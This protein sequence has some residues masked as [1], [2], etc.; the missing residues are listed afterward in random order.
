MKKIVSLLLAISVCLSILPVTSVAVKAADYELSN[1]RTAAITGTDNMGN[2]CAD[3][4]TTWDCIWFG[5]YPQSDSTGAK[6]EPIKWRVLSCSGND[7]FILAD[8]SLDC[9]PYNKQF[10]ETSWETCTLR[11]WLNGTFFKKAFKTGEQS[12]VRTTTVVND[13]NSY[14]GVDG[15]NDTSDKVYVLSFGELTNPSYGFPDTYSVCSKTRAA[16][17][18]EYAINNGAYIVSSAPYSG[19][20]YWWTRSFGCDDRN[21]VNSGF[22]GY[23]NKDGNG[24][25]CADHAV[26]PALHINLASSSWSYAGTVCSDGTVVEPKNSDQAGTGSSG[27]T[28]SKAA[29]AALVVGTVTQISGQSYKV[30]KSASGTQ[31]G[32]VAFTKAPNKKKVV[33]PAVVKLSDGKKYLVT[34][35]TAKAFTSKKIRQVT[36]GANVTKIAKNAFAKSKATRLILKTKKLKKAG[37]KGSLRGSKIKV[38]QVKVGSKASRK[39]LVKTYKKIFTKKNAGKKVTIK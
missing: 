2:A 28:T 34:T 35:V 32:T 21:V 17:S 30:V 5:S 15:G 23:M 29:K 38:I 10:V 37:I 20:G 1:P 22:N 7:A 26:R 25:H 16:R 36:V 31:T 33:I 18:T 8:Q 27:G 14:Y 6:S 13:A 3:L 4:K 39:K 12:A 9:Q 24:V 19:Y 11:A